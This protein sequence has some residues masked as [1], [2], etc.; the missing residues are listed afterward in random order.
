MTDELKEL[1]ARLNRTTQ[2]KIEARE[3]L[4]VADQ[5]IADLKAR[6]QKMEEY[7]SQMGL[8]LKQATGLVT[9]YTKELKDAR[10]KK[11]LQQRASQ[12]VAE[13]RKIDRQLRRL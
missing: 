3:Y 8:Q 2:R 12:K 9:R 5:S 1:Q 11:L 4:E 6:A 13:L 7:K 10:R